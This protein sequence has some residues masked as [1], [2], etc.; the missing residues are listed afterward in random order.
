MLCFIIKLTTG[1]FTLTGPL[2]LELL[3]NMHY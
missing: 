1:C 3:I 2:N